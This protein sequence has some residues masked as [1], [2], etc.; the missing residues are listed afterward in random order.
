MS[1]TAVRVTLE[2]DAPSSNGREVNIPGCFSGLES[3][4]RKFSIVSGKSKSGRQAMP[5]PRVVR[6][7]RFKFKTFDDLVYTLLNMDS[8][9]KRN[10]T[11]CVILQTEAYYT[12]DVCFLALPP[13][14]PVVGMKDKAGHN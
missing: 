5:H 10:M 13:H 1:D 12:A 14:S 4:M 3:L 9:R 7:E 2:N 6:S 11:H 8:Q